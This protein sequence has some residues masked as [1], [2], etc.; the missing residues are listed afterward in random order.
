EAAI[1]PPPQMC[2]DETLVLHLPP[3]TFEIRR[4]GGHTPACSVVHVPEEGVLFSGDVVMNGPC[5]GMREADAGRW[6]EALEWIEGLPVETVVP[7]HGE[8][9]GMDGVGR[10]KAYLTEIRGAMAGLVRSGR[11][12][13]E[14]AAEESMEKFFWLE[15]PAGEYWLAQRKDTFRQGLER[16]YDEVKREQAA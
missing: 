2:F 4:L 6:I 7:G 13:E 12:R 15:E 11:S 3:L 5:P 8:I 16:L 14:A 10:L 9:C 1:V